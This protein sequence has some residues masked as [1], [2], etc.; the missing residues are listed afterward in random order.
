MVARTDSGTVSRSHLKNKKGIEVLRL[1]KTRGSEREVGRVRQTWI[2]GG[3]ASGAIYD[4]E[5]VSENRWEGKFVVDTARLDFA[6]YCG[7]SAS[8]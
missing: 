6:V 7:D 5:G 2:A 4:F 8:N 3:G 1:A